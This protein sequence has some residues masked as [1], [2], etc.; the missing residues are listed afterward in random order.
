MLFFKS[1]ISNFWK[2]LGFLLSMHIVNKYINTMSL[3]SKVL[4][5]INDVMFKNALHTQVPTLISL[6]LIKIA[7]SKFQELLI[8]ASSFIL[9]KYLKFDFYAL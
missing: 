5:H 6:L 1:Y 7:P 3:T 8:K 9:F 2:H 4:I